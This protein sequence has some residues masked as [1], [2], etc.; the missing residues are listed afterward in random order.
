[1]G[2]ALLEHPGVEFPRL[3]DRIRLVV[4]ER[5]GVWGRQLRP[6]AAAWGARL[7][8]TRS[9]LDLVRALKRVSHPILLMDLGNRPGAGLDDLETAVREAPTL[10]ALVLAPAPHPEMN[11]LAREIGAVHVFEGSVAPPVVLDL[12]HRWLALARRRREGEGWQ[13]EETIPD[14]PWLEPVLPGCIGP[15]PFGKTQSE[16]TI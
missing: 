1:V 6:R 10:L 14:E 4:H 8:E 2:D 15:S 7:V 16:I 9:A 11:Q 12:L 13:K 3:Q 5:I